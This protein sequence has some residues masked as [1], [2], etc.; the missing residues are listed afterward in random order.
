LQFQ[1][2]RK[3]PSWEYTINEQRDRL[4]DHLLENPSLKPKVPEAQAKAYRYAVR[5]ASQETCLP[6]STF[7]AQCPWTFE[8]IMN[9]DFWPV[10]AQNGFV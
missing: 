3:T 9:P 8:Q 6:V 7:P 2:E 10:S 1:P 4:A 5:G